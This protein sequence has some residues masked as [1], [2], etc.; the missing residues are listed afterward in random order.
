[1]E[2]VIIRIHSLL[3]CGGDGMD[4]QVMSLNMLT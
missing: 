2:T 3:E 4:V 1:M